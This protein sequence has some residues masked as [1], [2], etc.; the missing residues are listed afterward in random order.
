MSSYD[1]INETMILLI[2]SWESKRFSSFSTHFL[3]INIA[4]LLWI[5]LQNNIRENKK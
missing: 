1:D 5:E 4:L 3:D 2:W